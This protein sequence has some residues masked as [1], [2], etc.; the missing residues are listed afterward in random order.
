[1]P[2][3]VSPSLFAFTYRRPGAIFS[4]KDQRE[5]VTAIG[6][7]KGFLVGGL[8]IAC[9]LIILVL[10]HQLR[11]GDGNVALRMLPDKV[12]VQVRDVRYTE[13][14]DPDALW[15][16]RADTATYMKEDNL[17][18]FDNIR[19]KLVTTGGRVYRMTADRGSFHTDTKNIEMSGNVVA[20]SDSGERFTT[21][22]LVY[23]VKE[24][25]VATN[26]LVSM[27]N[28]Q[29]RVFGTGMTLSLADRTFSLL[30][31]VRAELNQYDIR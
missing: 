7:K 20:L 11:K 23:Y 4:V 26:D 27:E 12:D 22:R 30:S 28:Q 5:D 19:V 10:S 13:V 9:V 17:S 8:F 3:S 24:K 15:E 21:D 29:M 1:V 14:G 31:N 18:L 6:V 2:A 25:K 16:I